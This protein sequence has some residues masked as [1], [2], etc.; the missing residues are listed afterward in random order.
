MYRVVFTVT[1]RSGKQ[2]IYH[3]TWSSCCCTCCIRGVLVRSLLQRFLCW[4]APL[5][6]SSILFLAPLFSFFVIAN[7]DG[8][9]WD[10]TALR[11]PL[12]IPPCTP[13]TLHHT[14]TITPTRV[15]VL[16][17]KKGPT[18]AVQLS[19]V[20]F[21]TPFVSLLPSIS[22]MATFT[23][24]FSLL[25]VA[26]ALLASNASAQCS[27]VNCLNCANSNPNLCLV[28]NDGYSLTSS[29]AC[30]MASGSNGA[31]ALQ[32]MAVAVLVVLSAMLTHVL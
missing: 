30:I 23:T 9:R 17:T 12:C 32:S 13:K 6:L 7:D 8:H 10:A 14:P 22:V 25:V 28:C 15:E 11:Y 20:I 29:G 4:P 21:P 16:R 1:G 19:H 3:G 18:T 27:I 26:L 24:M 5:S 31:L 2:Y